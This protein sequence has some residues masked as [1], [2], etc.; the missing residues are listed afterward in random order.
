MPCYIHALEL[1]PQYVRALSNLG[2]SYGNVQNHEAAAACYLKSISLNPEA[3]HIWS[4]LVMTF[5]SM[6]RADLV[7]KAQAADH[8]AFRADFDF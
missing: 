1:K 6:G 5:T 3:T 2:I 8:N 4:Y 7:H